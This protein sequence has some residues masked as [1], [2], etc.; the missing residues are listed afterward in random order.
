VATKAAT[1]TRGRNR[2]IE[3]S[4]DINSNNQPA[5]TELTRATGS[6]NSSNKHSAAQ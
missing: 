5:V 4:T 6:D 1:A 3:T 2:K